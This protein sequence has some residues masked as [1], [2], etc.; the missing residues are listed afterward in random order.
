MATVRTVSTHDDFTDQP[1]AHAVRF[2][3]EH[4]ARGFRVIEIDLSEDNHSE[5]IAALR[6]YADKGRDVTA[7]VLGAST[8]GDAPAGNGLSVAEKAAV[9]AY[10]RANHGTIGDRGRLPGWA[11]EA[12]RAQDPNLLRQPANA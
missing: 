10:V 1:G 12:W 3:L 7:E 6:P 9:R 11:I 5:L 4:E 8:N 2:G